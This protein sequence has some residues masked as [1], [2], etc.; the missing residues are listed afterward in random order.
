MNFIILTSLAVALGYA[1]TAT[2]GAAMMPP[3]PEI[4]RRLASLTMTGELFVE[5]LHT[6]V[7]GLCGILLANLLGIGLGL[8]AGLIR[9]MD[10]L[11]R[12]LL[13]ALNAC[14]PVVWI[15]LAMVWMGTGGGVPVFVVAAATL[16]P[17]FLSTVEGI[18]AIDPRLIAMSRLY[19]VPF[20]VRLK[21]LT[22]PSAF[23]FWR[24]AFAHTAA[25][26]WKVATVAEFLGSAD[27]IGARIYWSYHR[28]EMADLYAWTLAIVGFGIIID[29]GLISRLHSKRTPVFPKRGRR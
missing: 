7:R 20:L 28:L 15:S 4:L 27:G 10:R 29:T 16:P 12:P 17:V 25:A 22:I 14:P 13:T 18:Q 3:P 9:P 8:C 21:G 6:C 23:P 19:R 26:A 2:F 11:F 1:A 5:A 24:T